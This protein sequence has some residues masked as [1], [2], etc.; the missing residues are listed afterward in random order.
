MPG[1]LPQS[2]PG[3]SLRPPG[4]FHQTL[5]Q[6]PH[7]PFLDP[8]TCSLHPPGPPPLD[9][10]V[11]HSQTCSPSTFRPAAPLPSDLQPTSPSPKSA[12]P[13]PTP[14]PSLGPGIWGSWPLRLPRS[15]NP[16][17]ACS[18]QGS[19]PGSDLRC[20]RP[21]LRC[22]AESE[23]SSGELGEASYTTSA[24]APGCRW[25][26]LRD[27]LF[28][29][30]AAYLSAPRSQDTPAQLPRTLGGA[31]SLPPQGLPGALWAGGDRDGGVRTQ[32]FCPYWGLA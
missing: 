28:L 30:S 15:C 7:P 25:S 11:P 18:K 17:P 31:S 32:L 8:N 24:P 12:R 5:S 29:P 19:K 26:R 23:S 16:N 2:L 21:R 3:S 4:L 10:Q 20:C 1:L 22:S 27:T 14:L 9:L 13:S 6:T